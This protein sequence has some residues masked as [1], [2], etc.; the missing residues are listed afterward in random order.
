MTPAEVQPARC[1]NHPDRETMVRCS[2]CG[3]PI[4]PDCMVYSPVG[5]KCRA[6]AKL[7]KSALIGLK[8]EGWVKAAAAALGVGTAVGFAYY[9]F[10]AGMGFFF[11]VFFLGA[12]I[13]YLVGE[14]V[15]RAGGYYHGR[16]T[17]LLA[18]AGTVWAFVFPPLLA[19]LVRFGVS[20]DAVVFS[21]SGGA[22]TNWVVMAVAGYVAYQR[23]R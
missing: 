20:W 21:L 23:N 15:F 11:F 16:E 10:L 4:C 13:G 19:S 12:G 17:A 8:R 9:L 14:A 5:I 7:P 1:A 6:C 2:D 18:V 3:K 22:V